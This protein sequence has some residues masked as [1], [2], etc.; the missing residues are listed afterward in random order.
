MGIISQVS[1]V[2]G[3]SFDI[4]LLIPR[5]L[6]RLGEMKGVCVASGKARGPGLSIILL[7]FKICPE[8]IK[9]TPILTLP[10]TDIGIPNDP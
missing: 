9:I 7:F 4:D 5:K 8:Y 2:M 6:R 10:P 3:F 1:R